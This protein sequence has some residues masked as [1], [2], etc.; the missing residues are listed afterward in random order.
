MTELE[1]LKAE[2]EV[3]AYNAAWDTAIDDFLAALAAEEK[4][5]D[6]G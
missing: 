3:A 2:T 5:Q 1:K 4:E 6:N